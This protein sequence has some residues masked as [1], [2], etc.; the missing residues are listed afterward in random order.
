M[1]SIVL[2]LLDD[3]SALVRGAACVAIGAVI[4]STSPEQ[5]GSRYKTIEQS[6]LSKMDSKEEIEVHQSLAK[7]LCTAIVMKPETFRGSKG[8]A[9]IDGAL[10]LSMSSV[11]K[12]QHAFNDFL[13]LALRVGDF[14]S[15]GEESNVLLDEYIS[16][17]N[18]EN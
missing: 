8:L 12:V 15:D 11:Q 17:A 14:K 1:S 9:I 6:I 13:W 2:K 16:L 4:G 7:G 10:K 18:Y 3:E 5:E